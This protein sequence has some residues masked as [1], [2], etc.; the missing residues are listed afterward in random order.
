M[1][2]FRAA[3]LAFTGLLV[4]SGLSGVALQAEPADFVS[5]RD[6]I[7]AAY[8]AALDALSRGD[9]EAAL[10]MDTNDW[11]SVVVGQPI[12]TK[13]EMATFTRRDIAG[14]KPPPGWKAVW[15]PDYERTGVTTGIQLYDL[16]VEGKAATVLCLV[17]GAHDET[18]GGEK[19]SVWTG[20]HVRDS[21]TQTAA[22]W[23]RRKHEKLTINERMVD[24][25]PSK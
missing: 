18:I 16:K 11:T 10:Q 12:R 22:G 4:S 21:W 17:G 7:V 23:K 9:A 25:K 15:H 1:P 8:Q 6:Q 24:G 2:R 5:I 19:H 13:Q 14:M 20:S 3:S